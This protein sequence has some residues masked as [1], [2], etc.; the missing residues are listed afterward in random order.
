MQ[1]QETDRA[2]GAAPLLSVVVATCGRAEML[3][4]CLESLLAQEGPAFEVVCVDDG[5]RDATPEVLADLAR[6]HGD[7]LR[8]LRAENR[9]PGPARNAAVAVARGEWVV[10]AD[11]DTEAPPG[12]LAALW[13]ARE[14]TGA[15]A[16]AYALA[17]W[18]NEGPAA[19]YLWFRHRF[20]VGERPRHGYI[21]PAFLLLRRADWGRAGGFPETRLG[22]AEDYAFCLAL[23]RAGVSIAFEPS[24]T[25]RH[26]F[27]D[28]WDTARRKVR[29]AGRDGGAVYLAAGRSR[30]ALLLHA[31][32]KLLT[33]P[34]WC[35]WAYPPDL[36][37]AAL[38]MEA[39]FFAE[40]V[41]ACSPRS[42]SGLK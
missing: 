26:H 21:G 34:G 42:I 17:P 22:A 6:A 25:V 15:D 29:A 37:P 33:A 40:R 28:D 3:R 1:P 4:A 31:A 32:A 38:R 35:L 24:I 13:A 5:S 30:A 10:V 16:V 7:R 9:G 19:R 8:A 20:T 14:R 41:R 36:Y 39:L 2:P 11:D 12:W 27:E 18:G 23:R